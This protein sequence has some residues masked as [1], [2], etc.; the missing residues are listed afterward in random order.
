MFG[1]IIVEHERINGG[2]ALKKLHGSAGVTCGP[3]CR[4]SIFVGWATAGSADECQDMIAEPVGTWFTLSL[5]EAETDRLHTPTSLRAAEGGAAGTIGTCGTRCIR[6]IS[7]GHVTLIRRHRPTC[8]G[9]E[10]MWWIGP[11]GGVRMRLQCTQGPIWF[12]GQVLYALILHIA[13]QCLF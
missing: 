7:N 12:E 11:R 5:L 6:S 3:T 13:A 2:Q 9:Y 4:A 10:G 1:N 8:P